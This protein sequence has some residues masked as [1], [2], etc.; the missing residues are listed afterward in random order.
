[1]SWC[2]FYLAVVES[3]SRQL[4]KSDFNY[5]GMVMFISRDGKGLMFADRPPD[6]FPL[7]VVI[8]VFYEVFRMTR[9]D[10]SF[11]GGFPYEE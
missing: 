5:Q 7:N 2:Y 1:M 4:L 10:N 6:V 3:H 9:N 11:P 8:L